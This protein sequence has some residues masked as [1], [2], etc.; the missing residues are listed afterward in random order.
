[1][2]KIILLTL[3][4]L[5]GCSIPVT[6]ETDHLTVIQKTEHIPN[7]DGVLH[8]KTKGYSYHYLWISKKSTTRPK[9]T[10]DTSIIEEP[11]FDFFDK[12]EEIEGAEKKLMKRPVSSTGTCFVVGQ[13]NGYYYAITAK[14]VIAVP[15]AEIFIDHQKGEIVL[16]M[17]RADIAILRFKSNKT[18]PVYKMSVNAKILDDAWIVG[19]PGNITNTIRKFTVKGNICNVSKTEIWFSGGG[20][21]GMSGGPIFNDK[22]EVIGT[23]SRFLPSL[24]PCDNFVNNVPARFFKYQ[25]EAIISKEKIK[26]IINKINILEKKKS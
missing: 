13:I 7:T 8:L 19:Y 22:N 16:M 12:G 6:I 23:A 2:Y 21:K 11:I 5:S 4:I 17:H 18:Y 20:A 1:M 15:E 24:Y 10:L 26:Q 9:P 3:L 14:H 25:L